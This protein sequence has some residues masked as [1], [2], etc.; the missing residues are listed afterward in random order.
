MFMHNHIKSKL[1]FV[2]LT[3]ITLSYFL[4]KDHPGFNGIV[5]WGLTLTGWI[6]AAFVYRWKGK[7]TGIFLEENENKLRFMD[8][9][10]VLGYMTVTGGIEESPY[11]YLIYLGIASIGLYGS[12]RLGLVYS[13]LALVILVGYDLVYHQTIEGRFIGIGHVWP[14]LCMLPVF[15]LLADMLMVHFQSMQE[16]EEIVLD[17]L[18]TSLAKAI[19]S[20]DSYTLG[21]STRVQIYSLAIGNELAL[22]QEDMFTLRY[23]AL[24]HDIGKIH[25]PSSLLNKTGRPTLDEWNELKSHSREGARIMEGLQKLSG[26]RDIILYHHEKYDGTGYPEGLAGEEIP[27]L[28]AIVNVADSFDAMTS[29]RSYN[30]PKTV[31]EG[32][33]EIRNCMGKQFHP[34]AAAAALALFEKGGWPRFKQLEE[35]IEQEPDTRSERDFVV[36]K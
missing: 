34:K 18:V 6:I 19:G 10:F 23:G 36:S 27:F 1:R 30:Q 3:V 28:A 29:T 16:N 13:L 9:V 21:H 12:R 24:L 7:K 11:L 5:F 17:Q 26:V 35:K 15:G 32:M 33:E 20:K 14:K 2:S 25:I 31:E 22:N 4:V 8:F